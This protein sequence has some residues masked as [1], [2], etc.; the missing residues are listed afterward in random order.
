MNGLKKRLS[1]FPERV[2]SCLN[3]FSHWESIS[4]IR[5][6]RDKPLSL[7]SFRGNLFLDEKGR[8]CG[9]KE[10]LY[11]DQKEIRDFICAFCK[12]SVYRYFETLKEGFLVDELGYRL[13][14][15]PDKNSASSFLPER[16]EGVNLRIPRVV[17]GAAKPLLTE[18]SK[19]GLFST[20]ILSPPGAG[21]TTLLRDLGA[22]LSRGDTGEAYR[23]AVIDER[24]ELFPDA[25]SKG[26]GSLDVLSGYKKAE[27]IACAVRLFSP[28]VILCDEIGS[29]EDARA[30]LGAAGSGCLFFASAHA[31]SPKD[32]LSRPVIRELMEAGIFTYTAT[33]ER[34]PHEFYRSTLSLEKV[35]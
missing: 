7:T 22:A 8:P 24:G 23:V 4:E 32:V 13:G 12:G 21:K 2:R 16:F 35:I 20:L 26:V 34:I 14:V 3:G 25:F 29:V 6:R 11:T 19:K 18:F 10:A 27:G 15:C 30:I 1:Y 33:L 28:Q 5:M 17:E 31:N 9:V